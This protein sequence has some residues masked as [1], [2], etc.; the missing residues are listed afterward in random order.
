[1][2]RLEALTGRE[3]LDSRGSPTLEATARLASGAVGVAAVPSG[4]STGKHEAL[5]LRDK[6]SRF[7]GKGVTK[8]I[9]HLSE[10]LLPGLSNADPLDQSGFDQ[11]LIDLD[12]TPNK[13]KL[14]AN[15]LLGTSLAVARAVAAEKKISLVEHLRACYGR[16]PG[17]D[18][19]PVPMM[20]V[21]NGGV[22][23]A[24][25]L[26]IQ[27]FMIVP[28]GLTDP[29]DAVRAGSEVYHTLKILL[30]QRGMSVD[31]G[32]EGGFAPRLPNSV[33]GLELLAG[34]I[35]QSGYRAGRELSL[36]LDCAASQFFSDKGYWL[37]GKAYS[38]D[39]LTKLYA[40]WS[41]RF[42]I[43]SI[44]DGFAED[45]WPAWIDGTSRLGAH[46][47]LIG[48]DL[49]V[50][51]TALLKK[52]IAQKAGNVILIKPNQVGTLTETLECI[53]TAHQAGWKTIISH[54]SGET[55]DTFIVDLAVAVGA[56]G[57]KAG[58]PCR[59]ERT[60]KYNRL[61]EIAG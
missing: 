21:I 32:D 61:M 49:L 52:A 7:H 47:L 60:V 26:S 27:E 59:G 36:G 18:Q 17:C 10:T 25:G 53:R 12:G 22:H 37:D 4:A 41:A 45:D 39:G 54:R 33:S 50:T 29:K 34:A 56:W 8:C 40:S 55:T 28:L 15:T 19:P 51:H 42:P 24:A 46:T 44:E 5:E 31:V 9:R 16:P 13:S 20:N 3:I 35:E 38:H 58:A 14:G 57:L 6:D 30:R 43:L 2:S 48:D 1:M 23:S 11:I